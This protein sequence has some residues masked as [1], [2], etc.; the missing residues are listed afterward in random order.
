MKQWVEPKLGRHIDE[1]DVD[2][3]LLWLRVLQAA[4]PIMHCR[5]L[6]PYVD[7]A[8]GDWRK[9]HGKH[10]QLPRGP[11]AMPSGGTLLGAGKQPVYCVDLPHGV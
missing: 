11:A 2:H 7:S 5:D 1:L 3:I 4:P 8:L 10:G 6:N 9:S